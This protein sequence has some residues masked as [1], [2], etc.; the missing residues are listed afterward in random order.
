[1]EKQ[2]LPD[3]R[4]NAV[5]ADAMRLEL[6][7]AMQR[8]LEAIAQLEANQIMIIENQRRINDTLRDHDRTLAAMKA[9]A[10]DVDK[11]I[12]RVE[13]DVGKRTPQDKFDLMDERIDT[14]EKRVWALGSFDG[15]LAGLATLLHFLD[16]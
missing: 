7:Q 2:V 14:L 5:S 15:L 9:H 11:D 3:G 16:P 8:I 1:M 13:A 6:A 12:A 4:T 10:D